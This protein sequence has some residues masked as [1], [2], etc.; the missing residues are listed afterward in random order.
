MANTTNNNKRPRK[1]MWANEVARQ[2][3]SNNRR[4]LAREASVRQ[5]NELDRARNDLRNAAT[6]L[7]SSE[8]N[9]RANMISNGLTP[10]LRAVMNSWG[11]NVPISMSPSASVSA[12]TDFKKVVVYHDQ[13]LNSV[14]YD[15]EGN[16]LP[17]DP[18]LLRQVAAET[19]G[20]FYH[21]VGHLMFTTPLPML[22][23]LSVQNL[24]NPYIPL[25]SNAEM[26]VPMLGGTPHWKIN[27]NFQHAW[28]VLE[29]QRMESALVEESPQIASYLTVLVVR[30]MIHSNTSWALLAG[31]TYL[32]DSVRQS[33]ERLWSVS[34]S[35]Y[36]PA[37][38]ANVIERYCTAE[39][40]PTM[41][42]CVE[43]MRVMLNGLSTPDSIDKHQRFTSAAQGENPSEGDLETLEKV[44]QSASANRNSSRNNSDDGQENSEA[45]GEAGNQESA[46]DAERKP[47]GNE[48]SPSNGSSATGDDRDESP[49]RTYEERENLRDAL[50]EA[51][52]NLSD[53]DTLTEDLASMNEAYNNDDGSLPKYEGTTQNMNDDLIQQA[54][55]VADDIERAFSLAT[56][57]CAPHWETGQRRGF[58]EPVRY[59]TRQPGDLEIFRGWADSGEPG[60]DLA[61]SLFLDVSGSMDGTGEELGAAAWA[62]KVACDRLNIECDVTL[63]DHGGYRLWG[64]EDRVGPEDVPFVDSRGGTDPTI[65]FQSIL[66]DEREK[67]SHLVLVMT[68]G[69]WSD[70]NA[71]L[72]CRHR[73]MHTAVFF[74]NR[75]NDCT[76]MSIDDRLLKRLGPDEA[77]QIGDLMQIPSAVEH[78]LVSLL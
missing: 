15:E 16:V 64:T 39:D 77:Y 14:L 59:M 66:A 1:K 48:S 46:E 73:N 60:H 18:S 40:A 71:L 5:S 49:V 2:T 24:D 9:R 22:L 69:D 6:R 13:R 3:H 25:E 31:R 37:D 75:Y 10:R 32:P 26:V 36:S 35:E 54:S 68:D 20:L 11:W 67:A 78:M 43:Q 4:R 17:I 72:N 41:V 62:V 42:E 76:E 57:D 51:V 28:N 44:G 45:Q 74:L 8:T 53:D 65:A 47:S 34:G 30:N 70:S 50:N 29:D 52:D 12:W 7:K 55:M 33:S 27:S 38:I 19:R 58:L 63:F 21:E 56:Q 61:V 23:N